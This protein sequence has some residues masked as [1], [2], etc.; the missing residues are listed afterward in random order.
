[1]HDMTLFWHEQLTRREVKMGPNVN[2]SCLVKSDAVEGPS[3]GRPFLVH[4]L[5]GGGGGGTS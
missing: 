1:M 2:L 4:T 3:E 5:W